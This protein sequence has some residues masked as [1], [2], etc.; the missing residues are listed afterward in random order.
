MSDPFIGQIILFAGNFAPRDWALCNGQLLSI[1]QNSAL[2]SILGT[3]YGGDGQVTFALPDLQGRVAIGNGQGNGL[4]GRVLG[5]L[6]GTENTTLTVNQ[7]PAHRHSLLA[8]GTL[9]DSN[10]PNAAALA[11]AAPEETQYARGTPGTAMST[12]SIGLTGSSLPIDIMPP[13]LTLNYI[14]ALFGV[15]PSRN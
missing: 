13:Y 14:I 10:S 7:L 2:F 11:I 1:S 9:G 15:F 5:E 4:S 3:T 12:Q 8:S 6:A